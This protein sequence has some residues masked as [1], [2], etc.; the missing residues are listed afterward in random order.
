MFVFWSEPVLY[1]LCWVRRLLGPT[2]GVG[3]VPPEKTVTLGGTM[4]ASGGITAVGQ[5]AYDPLVA[6]AKMTGFECKQVRTMRVTLH[7]ILSF[8][9]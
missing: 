9:G 2:Q 3:P 4:G 7:L 5:N 1:F 6:F 8:R